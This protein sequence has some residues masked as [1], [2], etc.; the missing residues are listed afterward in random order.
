MLDSGYWIRDIQH[1]ASSNPRRRFVG[2]TLIELLVVV[3]IIAILAA[4]LLPALR[5]A[6]QSARRSWGMSNLRQVGLA[7]E[8]YRG[9]NNG[10]TPENGV[11]NDPSLE[12]LSSY[13]TSNLMFATKASS[14][15]PG[16]YALD[17]PT[18]PIGVV[19]ANMNVMG[20]RIAT[21]AR[22]HRFEEIKYPGTTFVVAHQ[23]NADIT[24]PSTLDY[25]F[26]GVYA[27]IR[28]P[29]YWYTGTCFYF[30]DGHLEWAAYKGPNAS[31]WWILHPNPGPSVVGTEGWYGNL[32]E[33]FGP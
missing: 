6:R 1:P 22:A 30:V 12:L 29:L 20:G 7:I 8:M 33:I 18:T 14:P 24:G 16:F 2:F 9:D 31:R 4:M 3:A 17:A 21:Q 13:V 15:A 19:G 26:I 28:S 10:C 11:S 5:N 23:I 27:T 25:C 32:Y